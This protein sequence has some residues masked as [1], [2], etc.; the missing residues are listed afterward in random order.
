LPLETQAERAAKA[1]VSHRTQKK[2]DAL[3]RHAPSLFKQVQAGKKKV[4]AAYKEA[5]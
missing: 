3:A 5:G 2:L 4:D 1:G